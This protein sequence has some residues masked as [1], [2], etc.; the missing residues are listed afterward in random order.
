MRIGIDIDDT[1]TDTSDVIIECVNKYNEDFRGNEEIIDDLANIARGVLKTESV[2]SFFHTY[3][4]QILSKPK[5]KDNVGKVIEN[6]MSQGNKIIFITARS[7]KIFKN[8]E[9]LTKDYLQYNNIKYH[10][11]IFDSYN[12]VY[13]CIENK[14]DIMIDDSENTCER[15]LTTEVKPILFNSICNKGKEVG[16]TRVNNWLELETVLTEGI[17]GN[18]K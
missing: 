9:K 13:D 12:K 15:L 14:I 11:I 1:I 3:A 8:V 17:Y 6:L 10:K 2:K 16:C 5:I 18:Y 7:E 4:E